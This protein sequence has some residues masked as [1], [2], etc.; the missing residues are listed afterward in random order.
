MLRLSRIYLSGK[1]RSRL[2]PFL[3]SSRSQRNITQSRRHFTIESFQENHAAATRDVSKAALESLTS[4]ALG[5]SPLRFWRLQIHKQTDFSL[6]CP[7]TTN[8]LVLPEYLMQNCLLELQSAPER[9]KEYA[10]VAKSILDRTAPSD[11]H[12][13][14]PQLVCECCR[15]AF[16]KN[17]PK[18]FIAL[19]NRIQSH[20]LIFYASFL[21]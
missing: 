19:W 7:D 14:L 20:H 17:D 1:A 2:A 11:K 3:R 21:H 13:H 6:F 15:A 9:Y 10:A 5:T 12:F 4:I 18:T 16:R 8:Q